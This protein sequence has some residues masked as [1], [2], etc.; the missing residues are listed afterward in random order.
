MYFFNFFV[1][2][3]A[4]SI[5]HF[6][7]SKLSLLPQLLIDKFS[8]FQ[9]VRYGKHGHYNAHHDSGNSTELQCCHLTST[10]A[11]SKNCRICRWVG[12]KG[13]TQARVTEGVIGIS[14]FSWF[15]VVCEGK[16][17]H[18]YNAHHNPRNSTKLQCCH[19]TSTPAK[20][21]TIC[22]WVGKWRVFQTRV[23][24]W[25]QNYNVAI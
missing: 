18:L 15:H 22:M 5:F 7:I 11:N 24:E 12:K 3:L 25:A 19:L 1:L 16:H 2:I 17:R 8:F 9:V 4:V 13:V 20:N 21:C 6:R 23:T 10:P 14:K